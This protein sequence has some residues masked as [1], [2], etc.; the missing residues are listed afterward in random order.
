MSVKC[1]IIPIEKNEKEILDISEKTLDELWSNNK[2]K[3]S[4]FVGIPT[5]VYVVLSEMFKYV[6]ENKIEDLNFMELA[7]VGIDEETGEPTMVPGQDM[8]LLVKSDDL[9]EE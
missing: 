2:I 7:Y 9:T 8:R 1:Q 5:I 4:N 3:L 6:G